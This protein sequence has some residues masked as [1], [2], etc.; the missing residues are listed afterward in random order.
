M[1]LSC[2]NIIVDDHPAPG[3]YLLYNTRT[4]A[5]VKVENQLMGLLKQLD[6]PGSLSLRFQYAQ[7]LEQLYEMGFIVENKWDDVKRLVSF[8][9]D[10][11]YKKISDMFSVTVLTTMACNFKCTYCFEENAR[12][13]V[14]MDRRTCDATLDWIKGRVS[15]LDYARLFVT[16]YGGEPLLNE[17][18]LEYVAT[19]LRDWC[20]ARGI[21]FRFMI[22]TN[23]YLMT[24]ERVEKYLP[25]GLSD[26]RISLDGVDEEHDRKRPL[27]GGSGT[28]AQIMKNIVDNAAKVRIGISVSYDKDGVGHVARLLDHL[29]GIGILPQLGRF[30]FSPVHASLGPLSNPEKIRGAACLMNYTDVELLKS[31]TEINRLM[32]AKGLSVQRGLP[33]STCPLGCDHGGFSIDPEGRLYACNSMLGYPEFS[34]GDVFQNRFNDKRREFLNMDVGLGC[35]VDCRYLP[36]CNGGCR[37][38]AFVEHGRFDRP[39]CKAGYLDR[40]AP[41]LVKKEYNAL[42]RQKA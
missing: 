22:Q 30:L 7:E 11:K 19:D 15:R 29:D 42:C 39:Y 31:V 27:R 24:R 8:L 3:E 25:L 38:M 14:A 32:E 37:L 21:G 5:L 33:V 9:G 1:Q 17:E 26:V 20:R 4:Q 40:M 28:F 35:P 10:L 2:H 12:K 23:G 13:P 36:V 6:R 18:A 16:F 34:V 41:E